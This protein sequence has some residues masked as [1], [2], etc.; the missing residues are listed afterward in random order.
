MANFY[1]LNRAHALVSMLE[2][3]D[4][5]CYIRNEHTGTMYWLYINAIGG[6]QVMV[7]PDCLS[8]AIDILDLYN[9]NAPYQKCPKCSS[10]KIRYIRFGVINAI[11]IF[12]GGFCLPAKKHKMRCDE[13]NIVFERSELVEEYDEQLE[14]LEKLAQE[15]KMDD[16]KPK[17]LP[18][19]FAFLKGYI[20]VLLLLILT[21]PLRYSETHLQPE[22]TQNDEANIEYYLRGSLPYLYGPII[23]GIIGVLLRR[24]D[25]SRRKRL[26]QAGRNNAINSSDI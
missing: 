21:A 6:Y 12:I 17:E 10:S 1:D 19:Y 23:G 18:I 26:E 20:I 25:E 4:I 22:V 8:E 16:V 9:T 14:E 3:N 24:V 11:G 2:A 13:C 7:S 5:E 15:S